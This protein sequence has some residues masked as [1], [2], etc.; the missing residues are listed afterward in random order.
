MKLII[1]SIGWMLIGS[2]LFPANA[3]NA[4]INNPKHDSPWKWETAVFLPYRI[5]N[6]ILNEMAGTAADIAI[7]EFPDLRVTLEQATL[8]GAPG[9]TVV[10][11]R[12]GITK[13]GGK[14]ALLL[15]TSGHLAPG[16]MRNTRK[17]IS[18]ARFG[19]LIDKVNEGV[20]WRGKSFMLPDAIA[21]I[22][23][24][25][26][27]AAYKKLLGKDLGV[28][29]PIPIDLSFNPRSK[30]EDDRTLAFDTPGKGR[31]NVIIE[32]PDMDIAVYLKDAATV[33]CST[34]LWVCADVAVNTG[35]PRNSPEVLPA[36]TVLAE[37]SPLEIYEKQAKEIETGR[38]F[39]NG[40][41]LA[42]RVNEIAG[43]EEKNRQVHV[44]VLNHAGVLAR[45]AFRV[46]P[47]GS[48]GVEVWPENDNGKGTLTVKP[49]ST[50]S[51]DKLTV[52]C[53]YTATMNADL[54]VHLDPLVSGGYGSSIGCKTESAGEGE[55]AIK[56]TLDLKVTTNKSA[57]VVS[58]VP[59]F[60]PGQK[61]KAKAVTDG[62]LKFKFLGDGVSID[63]MSV[64]VQAE[65][66][67]P[68]DLLPSIPLLTSEPRKIEVSEDVLLS[69]PEHKDQQPYLVVMPKDLALGTA[70]GFVLDFDLQAKWLTKSEYDEQKE[71]VKSAA[72]SAAQGPPLKLGNLEVLLGDIKIGENSF[73]MDVI[74]VVMKA[75]KTAEET[76]K[77]ITREVSQAGK[78]VEKEVARA[79]RN[80]EREVG[81]AGKNTEREIARGSK[82]VETT[83]AKAGKDIEREVGK[84]AKDV[85][86]NAQKASKWIRRT[87][88]F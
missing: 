32:P 67:V 85:E 40:N 58:L 45:K 79:G 2:A 86:N 53:D 38:A 11:A 43:L 47:F 60:D 51:S 84:A 39:V 78:N 80:I 83:V 74:R 20:K 33:F 71:A 18:N 76:G 19:I 54:H 10:T 15:E 26:I 48:G 66:D 29:I 46:E 73:L 3:Q 13:K 77:N 62:K 23:G 16:P 69:H 34:G 42:R 65:L 70:E 4:A 68:R 14:D 8:T 24:S 63:V 9:K 12:F 59:I 35:Q 75:V 81:T 82:N 64:G 50:W 30:D 49:G 5:P 57:T 56:G 31:V 7:D 87:F 27:N 52:T 22:T 36:D 55:S 61:L 28:D 44:K 1:A 6:A 41:M 21:K 17:G 25:R 88:G 37:V 72:K